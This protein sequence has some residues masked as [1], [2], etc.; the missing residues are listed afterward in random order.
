MKAIQLE[1][2]DT[3]KNSGNNK[4]YACGLYFGIKATPNNKPATAGGDV[5][6]IQVKSSHASICKGTD[7]NEHLALDGANRYAYITNDFLMYLMNKEM[8]KLF[9]EKFSYIDTDSKKNGGAKKI[10]LRNESEKMLEWLARAWQKPAS[11]I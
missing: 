10:R 9:V 5:L 4:E 3:Y 11:M 8:Y 2:I 1:K 6:D 7:L